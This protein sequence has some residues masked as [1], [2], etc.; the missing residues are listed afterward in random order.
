MWQKPKYFTQ[1]G[2]Q[3]VLYVTV[4]IYES[5]SQ[6]FRTYATGHVNDTKQTR[7]KTAHFHSATCNLARWLT[8]HSI[9]NIYRCST[10]PQLLY[11]WCHQS[12][13]FWIL[14]R[15]F[16]ASHITLCGFNRR[17]NRLTDNLETCFLVAN[18][19]EYFARQ[20]SLFVWE[21]KRARY[22]QR[23]NV[24]WNQVKNIFQIREFLW[25]NVF[26]IIWENQFV[27]KK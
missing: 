2:H 7:V 18:G 20:P 17:M 8:R 21:S 25:E 16:L 22:R 9:P 11:I 10:L 14:P 26:A 3:T 15:M 24:F 19:M 5:I 23:K 4:Q 1:Y 12:G 6:I 27:Y 13:I